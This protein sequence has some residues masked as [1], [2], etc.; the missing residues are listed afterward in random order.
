MELDFDKEIDALL[1]QT[2]RSEQFAAANGSTAPA[3][4]DADAISAFAENALPEKTRALYM[5]HLADCDRCRKILSNVIMLGF[6][7]EVSASSSIAEEIVAV[8]WYRRLLL[9]P[10]L[11]YGMGALVLVFGGLL[12]LLVLQNSK[13][14]NSAE[15]SQ[16]ANKTPVQTDYAV[17]SRAGGTANSV[18]SSNSNAAMPAG[19]PNFQGTEV[20][21][22]TPGLLMPM[23]EAKTGEE[24]PESRSNPATAAPATSA[25]IL[26]E[27]NEGEKIKKEDDLATAQAKPANAAKSVMPE[28][29]KPAPPP[30]PPTAGARRDE[31]PFEMMDKDLKV[32]RKRG[33]PGADGPASGRRQVNG[34]AFNRTGGVWYDSAYQ[35]QPTR[36]VRRGT[37]EYR[38]L[39]A[40]LRSI[41]ESL[42][43]TVVVVW[44]DGAYRIQ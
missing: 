8:P 2:A 21:E 4:I 44:R 13:Q 38:K 10:N 12:G 30:P 9:F 7:S 14:L 11:A 6:E 5:T 41:A 1:R 25:D 22:A 24:K 34:K 37:N 15:V 27:R 18:A 43:G 32:A 3:H 29:A 17:D 36:D 40:G 33:Q 35:G 26:T 28:P 23:D 42:G 19:A 16:V 20:P 39:D 31:A